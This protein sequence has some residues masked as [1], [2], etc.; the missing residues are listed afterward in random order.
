MMAYVDFLATK[1]VV[2]RSS[3]HEVDPSDIHPSL[4]GFQRDLVRWSLRKGRTA[5]SALVVLVVG[6]EMLARGG[7]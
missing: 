4:F 7:K 6:A 5:L 1:A 2:V 3:G